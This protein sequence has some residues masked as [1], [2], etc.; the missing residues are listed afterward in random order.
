M[1][2]SGNV[3]CA[4]RRSGSVPA[5]SEGRSTAP[6]LA[7]M[8]CGETSNGELAGTIRRA[9]KGEPTIE[10]GIASTGKIYVCAGASK[11]A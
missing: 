9:L 10:I 1:G 5:A 2:S 11:P 6:N 7:R 3:A 8:S 4:E